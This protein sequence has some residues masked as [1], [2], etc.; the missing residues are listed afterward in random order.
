MTQIVQNSVFRTT[1]IAAFLLAALFL[2]A[3]GGEAQEGSLLEST[4][5]SN[6][7]SNRDQAPGQNRNPGNSAGNGQNNAQED[8][9]EEIVD[10]TEQVTDPVADTDP[11][12][13]QDEAGETPIADNDD[14]GVEVNAY[15]K[16]RWERPSE[17]ENGEN[18]F[19]EDIGGYELRYREVGSDTYEVTELGPDA[20]E[21]VFENLEGNY[22][23]TIAVYDSSGLYSRFV[24]ITPQY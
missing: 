11:A 17:R 9:P 22:H 7:N 1:R 18:L 4:L 16:L 2:S 3:C 5:A 10:E 13:D 21:V 24:D 19:L 14:S 6:A 15:I 20:D 8:A 12:A 23:F